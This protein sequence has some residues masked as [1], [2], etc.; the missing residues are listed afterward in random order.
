M[1]TV[2]NAFLHLLHDTES[3]IRKSPLYYRSDALADFLKD[4]RIKR[5]N[6]LH[7]R[8]KRLDAERYVLSMVGLTNVGKSTLAHALLK[9][10]VAPRRNGP[11][12]SIP[13]E[14]EHGQEWLMK[15]YDVE[16]RSV[17]HDQFDSAAELSA[18]LERRVFDLPDEQARSIERVLV[19][20]PMDLL[21]SGLVFADT[22]GFGAAQSED[23]R[24]SHQARLVAY[25]NEHV[26]EVLFC[27][28]G[29]NCM[30]SREEVD[31][32]SSIREICSTVVVTKWDSEPDQRDREMRVY[33]AKFTHLFPLCRFMFVEA[34]WAIMGQDNANNGRLEASQVEELRTLIRR[35][36]S[37]AERR[38][39]LHQQILDAWDDLLELSREPLRETE[40][41]SLPWRDDALLRFRQAA[42]QQNLLLHV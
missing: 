4:F 16:T 36:G 25:V 13:V 37:P 1:N 33:K 7:R 20:G 12:T 26:A 31:F 42:G 18:A 21:E 30:V 11:A 9:H 38:L 19:R 14:Y 39:L 2:V 6:P 3:C 5:I 35:R 24:H 41:A 32:F 40:V 23:A 29:A 22:P 17:Q 28:S 10:P 8:L 27:L 15:T 34:K